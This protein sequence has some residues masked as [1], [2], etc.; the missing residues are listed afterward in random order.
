MAAVANLLENLNS[1]QKKAVQSIDGPVLVLAGAGSGKTRVLTYRVA[2]LLDQTNVKP[3]EILAVTFTNKAANEMKERILQLTNNAGKDIW[4]GTFHAI[5]SRILRRDGERL[6]FPRNFN[7]FDRDDQKRFLKSVMTDLNINLKQITIDMVHSRISRAKNNFIIPTAYAR[8]AKDFFEETVANVYAAYQNSLKKNNAMDFDD[9]L[10]NPIVLFNEFP[11]VLQNY[12]NRFKYILVDE[13]QDTNH[14][15]YL[16]LKK[17]TE[18]NKNLCVVGDDDQSIYKWRGADI[19]N[20]LNMEQDYPECKIYHLEQ[21]YRSTKSILDVANYVVKNNSQ[22]R[23]KTLWT[24]RKTGDKPVVVEVEDHISESLYI[25]HLLKNEVYESGRNFND[26]V[27]L[28]RTNAQSRVLEDA[29]RRAGIPYV[30][31]GGV[32]FYERKEI[33]DILAYLRLISNQKDSVCFKRIIN[34]PLRGIGDASLEKLETYAKDHNITLFEAAGRVSEIATLSKRV[35]KSISE[36]HHLISKYA[37]LLSEFSAGE[38]A[39]TLVDE[40]GL[41]TIFKEIGTEESLGRSENV[42][43]LLSAIA[44]FTKVRKNN[45][46]Q[47]FLEEVALVTDIDSWDKGSNAVTLMTLHSAKGLEFPVVFI[48]GLE[49]GLFPLT[50]TFDSNE[51]L[52]EERR[53]FYVGVTR[54]QDK[55]YL[56]WAAQRLRYGEMYQNLP[57][58]FLQEI[59]DHLVEY[60]SVRRAYQSGRTKPRVQ[61]KRRDVMPKYEDYSQEVPRLVMGSMVKHAAFGVGRVMA[62]EGSG[63]SLKITVRFNQV[64]TKKLMV[65]YANLEILN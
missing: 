6:G 1:V 51:E 62:K 29:L 44:N 50:R 24:D 18:K 8:S 39:R 49:E 61:K 40:I 21:N 17:L 3:W 4:I 7:V 64:G 59:D 16:M 60:K 14:T 9:L 42:M 46:L 25:V 2:Y 22:R 56:S 65:K 54:A 63:E 5:C 30:I 32:R 35:Q 15:Q 33:K 13:Y 36:F 57:S 37:N 31:V 26:F 11:E 53:L 43:E 55:L 34:Y 10:V 41:L 52:E 28:Y 48:A 23:D 38:L 47:Y 27:I 45:S 19:K 58:R 20:I 12:Q